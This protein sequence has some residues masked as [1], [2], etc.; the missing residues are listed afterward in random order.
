[1]KRERLNLYIVPELK[2]Y[3]VSESERLGLSQGAFITMVLQIYRQG[4]DL[5]K[6]LE[7]LQREIAKKE[8]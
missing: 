2:D 7:L 4:N 8:K 5:S 1:M 3:V 6:N